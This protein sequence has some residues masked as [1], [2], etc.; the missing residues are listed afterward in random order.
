MKFHD[1]LRAKRGNRGKFLEANCLDLKTMT[2]KTDRTD[3]TGDSWGWTRAPVFI[4][5]AVHRSE[6]G[7]DKGRKNISSELWGVARL[8]KR[9]NPS[10]NMKN[11]YKIYGD[12]LALL[13]FNLSLIDRSVTNYSR[14]SKGYMARSSIYRRYN[15]QNLIHGVLNRLWIVIHQTYCSINTWKIGNC[16]NSVSIGACTSSDITAF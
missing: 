13:D 5:L 14:E 11:L 15:S 8:R 12:P 2:Q 7:N 4:Q 9:L 16:S 6:G 1:S 3:L 10:V